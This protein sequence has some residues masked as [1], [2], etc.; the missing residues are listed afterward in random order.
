M[1]RRGI[2][3]FK[4]HNFT[5]GTKGINK[6]THSWK[7][8]VEMYLEKAAVSDVGQMACCPG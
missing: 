5:K 8:I 4:R 6:K 3:N 1:K 7:L 2:F